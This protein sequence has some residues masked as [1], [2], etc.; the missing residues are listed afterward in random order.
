MENEEQGPTS[1]MQA[2]KMQVEAAAATRIG[3]RQTNADAFLIDEV[4]GLYAVAD[5]MGDTPVSGLVARQALEAV[6]Q[7]FGAHWPSLPLAERT[8][9]EARAR[10]TQGIWQADFRVHAPYV[11]RSKRIGTTFAGI[12][13]CGDAL[14][15]AHVGDSRVYLLRRGKVHLAQLTADHT[16]LGEARRRGMP[17]DIALLS[18]HA[19]KLT[20]VLGVKPGEEVEPIVRRWEAGDIALLCTDGVS[21]H[22]KAEVMEDILLD[23]C[24]IR[25]AAQRIVDRANSAGGL[26]NA[27]VV[28]V[29]RVS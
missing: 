27:T 6:Q 7:M 21:D 1:G 26:D 18:P 19:H 8:P 11:P 14:C 29:R 20:R 15:A 25:D 23:A 9:E 16:S 10:I 4:A 22:V 5:G 24:D 13:V 2:K 28:L 17:E 3:G 12:V